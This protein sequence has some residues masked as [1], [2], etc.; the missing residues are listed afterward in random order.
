MAKLSAYA[1]ESGYQDGMNAAQQDAEKTI[2]ELREL[3]RDMYI[4]HNYDCHSCRYHQE[5]ADRIDWKCIAPIRLNE[6]A[7]ALGIEGGK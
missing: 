3:L 2:A 4:Y 7:R 6:R 1:Y 5:C